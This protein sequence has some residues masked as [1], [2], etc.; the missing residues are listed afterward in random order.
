MLQELA[1]QT[2]EEQWSF[3]EKENFGIL[4]SYLQYT[5]SPGAKKQYR[6]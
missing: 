2:L 5:F 3:G 4:R 1:N 6:L